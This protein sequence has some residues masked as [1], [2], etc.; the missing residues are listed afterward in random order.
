[1]S[2][3][4]ISVD[5]GK[6]DISQPED[7]GRGRPLQELIDRWVAVP[8][9]TRRG[10]LRGLWTSEQRLTVVAEDMSVTGDKGKKR[11]KWARDL[12]LA[13][14]EA[15]YMLRGFANALDPK[16]EAVDMAAPPPSV[17]P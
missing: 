8:R 2:D 3:V 5:D 9:D 12:L 15:R 1:M 4:A 17:K 13:T 6:R 11:R 7:D 16:P 14:R 10:V